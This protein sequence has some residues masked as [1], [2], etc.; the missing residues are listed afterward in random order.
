MPQH[1]I[2]PALLDFDAASQLTSFSRVTLAHWAR[3]DKKAPAGFP[4]PIRLNGRV[5]RFRTADL[6]AWVD[7]LA[8][9]HPTTPA[10]GAA[11]TPLQRRAGRPRKALAISQGEG[12]A[13]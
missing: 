9:A 11:P 1:A 8:P 12:G 4:K 2:Q 3:G 6:L 10:P 7:G 5:L 13:V